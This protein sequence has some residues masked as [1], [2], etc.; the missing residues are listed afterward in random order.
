MKFQKLLFSSLI[1]ISLASCTSWSS[2]L[3]VKTE[4][5]NVTVTR[6]DN[7]EGFVYVYV[8]GVGSLMIGPGE[9]GRFRVETRGTHTIRARYFGKNESSKLGPDIELKLEIDNDKHYFSVN[10]LGDA[11]GKR[12][13]L[14]NLYEIKTISFLPDSNGFVQFST[15]D[16]RYYGRGTWKIVDN[17]NAQNIYEIECLKMSGA[18]TRGHGMV[19][20]ASDTDNVSY[21]AVGIGTPGSY[22]IMKLSN[23]KYTMIKAWSGSEKVKPGYNVLNTLR[24]IK[25]GTTFI[26]FIND[27]PVYEFTDDEITG[28]RVGYWVGIGGGEEEEFPIEP[29]DVRFRQRP[30]SVNMEQRPSITLK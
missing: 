21:Y 28:N 11:N 29:V 7:L 19:F 13:E 25:Y 15:N 24:V 6:L 30:A 23:D 8:T 5:A 20:G 18:R 22:F 4:E 27:N 10:Y 12:T 16:A 1:I 26:V 9:T 2:R 3:G 14:K 17:I